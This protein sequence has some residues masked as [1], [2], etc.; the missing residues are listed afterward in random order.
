MEAPSEL[1]SKKVKLFIFGMI[2][3]HIATEIKNF[4]T[5]MNNLFHGLALIYVGSV[6]TLDNYKVLNSKDK[7]EKNSDLLSW[8]QGLMLPAV[9]AITLVATYISVTSGSDITGLIIRYF[10]IALSSLAMKT[11]MQG[12]FKETSFKIYMFDIAF[13]FTFLD[14][15]CWVIT[16]ILAYGYNET[17]RNG[18]HGNWISNNIFAICFSLAA[19]EN[20]QV[21]RFDQMAVILILFVVYDAY[22]VYGTTVMIDVA[23]GV[24]GPMKIMFPMTGTSSYSMLG[25]GDII[26]PGL[27]CSLCIRLDFIRLFL[28]VKEEMGKSTD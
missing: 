24:S 16:L 20:W 10:L 6:L 8:K 12:Y 5:I 3:L 19:I 21:G 9:A 17:I 14:L 4:S 27:M 22:F 13:G 23:Q 15:F 1:H 7:V 18:S 25:L 26:I 28:K 2:F 11:Y